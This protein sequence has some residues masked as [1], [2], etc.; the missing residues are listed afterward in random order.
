MSALDLETILN[1]LK[2][3][4]KEELSQL[5]IVDA[6]S[7]RKIHYPTFTADKNVVI[8]NIDWITDK[9]KIGKLLN[10]IYPSEHSLYILNNNAPERQLPEPVR[11]SGLLNREEDLG[12]VHF[13]IP[14]VAA[15]TSL[16][17]FQEIVARLRAPQGCPW[18]QEQT[19][20]SLRPNLMEETFEVLSALDEND[21]N[22]LVEELGDLLLQIVLHAQIASESKVFNMGDVISG[23]HKKIVN[24]HPHVFGKLKIKD[25]KGV[26]KN[27]EILKAAEREEK[28]ELKGQS[29]LDTVPKTLPALALAQ[30]YQK[31]VA[32][33]GFDWQT[34]EPVLDKVMEEIGEIKNASEKSTLGNELGDLLFAVVNLARWYGVDAESALRKANVRFFS[35]FQYIEKRVS[36]KGK[37]LMD[38]SLKELDK[39]WEEAK[40]IEE[41]H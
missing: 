31:R 29:I 27:W 8:L 15:P 41:K 34:I 16:E 1:L 10:A 2:K 9:N 5:V 30:A 11:I 23:I 28:G 21:D 24:R 6:A 3:L 26:I 39:F 13:Y 20:Q 18:D 40:T 36:E 19:H 37:S 32:R 33:V 12:N 38:F 17:A 7:L 4:E 35:R 25:T 14:P 22:A